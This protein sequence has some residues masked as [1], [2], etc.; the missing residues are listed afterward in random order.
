[1]YLP[2]KKRKQNNHPHINSYTPSKMKFLF[3]Y[4][5]KRKP[6]LTNCYTNLS[7]SCLGVTI[8]T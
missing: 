8:E 4:Q 3:R 2:I 5:N 7:C 6:Q 1:M